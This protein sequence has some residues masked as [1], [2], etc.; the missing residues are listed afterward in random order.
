MAVPTIQAW[1]QHVGTGPKFAVAAPA[2]LL[3]FWQHIPGI[4]KVFIAERNPAI[5]ATNITPW[6]ADTI[7]ILP[8]SPRTAFEAYLAGI[9]YRIGFTGKWRKFLLTHTFDRPAQTGLPHHQSLDPLNLLKNFQFIPENTKLPV[10]DIPSP[11]HTDIV[12]GHYLLICPGAEYGTAKRW[13]ADRYARLANILGKSRKIHIVLSGGDNDREVCRSISE[14]LDVPF[15]NTAGRTSLKEFLSLC[16]HTKLILCNDSGAMHAA[17]LFQTPGVALFGS[18]E[19]RWTGPISDSIKVLQEDVPC[20]PC[21]LR[22]CPIDFRCMQ[23]LS[24]D[25]VLE[26]CEDLLNTN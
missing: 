7:L 16:A 10:P 20:N 1:Q 18:T 21:F 26:A 11:D 3:S 8:N 24:E 23:Q 19:P 6:K 14:Q 5:T 9:P 2:N 12:K 17:S 13:P 15:T 22:E 25:R 4:D